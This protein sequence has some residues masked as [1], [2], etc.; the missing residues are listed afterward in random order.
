MK[1]S[2]RIL[3]VEDDEWDA[4]VTREALEGAGFVVDHVRDG[5]A[6]MAF[7]RREHPFEDSP[8]PAIVL[9]DLN[10]PR[11]DGREVLAEIKADPTL[12]RI[13][14]I[15]L[16]RSTAPTDIERAYDL[17]ANSYLH[18]PTDPDDYDPLIRA[19]RG[20]WVDCAVPA[21]V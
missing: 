13:P 5:E 10:L 17:H 16:T 14:V 20:F 18:K 7:L 21:A 8:R 3:L 1:G 4:L 11:K 15:V 2:A 9:L 19:I 6:T 12:R